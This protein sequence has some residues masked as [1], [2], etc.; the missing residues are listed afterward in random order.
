MFNFDISG[1]RILEV[2]CGI[3]LSSL[4]L[5]QRNADIS[6][7]DYHPEV[8]PFLEYN[9]ILNQGR[10][11]P[12]TRL[13]WDDGDLSMGTFDL[14]IGSDLLY[15]REHVNLL[16]NFILQHAKPTNEVIMVDPGRGHHARFSKRMVKMGYSHSQAPAKIAPYLDT[17]FKGQVLRYFK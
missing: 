1:K 14:I 9:V 7:T 4:V 8:K 3:G 15:E 10:E 12:F 11:I 16:S 5:N 6:A 17:P 2:G 13:G